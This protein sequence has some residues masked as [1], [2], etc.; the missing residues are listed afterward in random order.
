[1]SYDVCLLDQAR[2]RAKRREGNV[3]CK[4]ADTFEGQFTI[5]QRN[6]CI[7]K[8]QI[9]YTLVLTDAAK[10]ILWVSDCFRA[11]TGYRPYEVLGKMPDMFQGSSTSPADVLRL[12]E[13]LAMAQPV[14]ADL[15]NYRKNGDM[16]VCRVHI[17]PLYNTRQDLTHFLAVEWEVS[18]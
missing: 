8:L 2:Q 14:G 17:K 1:M 16:Y 18:R 5:Q 11:M 15:M 9:G 10:T 7:H 6:A 4:L 12:G 13:S 3:F